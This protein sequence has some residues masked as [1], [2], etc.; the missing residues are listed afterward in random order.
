MD[1]PTG[2]GWGKTKV[3]E[4]IGRRHRPDVVGTEGVGR[5]TNATEDERGGV[6]GEEGNSGPGLEVL[7]LCTIPP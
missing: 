2:P 4:V 3:V 6:R 5:R 1:D 7:R